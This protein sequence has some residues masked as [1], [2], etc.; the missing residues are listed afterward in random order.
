MFNILILIF[1][2]KLTSSMPRTTPSIEEIISIE[3]TTAPVN[4]KLTTPPIDYVKSTTANIEDNF[5]LTTAPV[6]IK[7]TTPPIDYVKSTTA[8]NE[9][10]TNISTN[11]FDSI[12]NYFKSFI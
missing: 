7:L 2:A 10:K 1:F 6:N 9:D 3:L 11:L 8:N 4:I 5:K 12:S